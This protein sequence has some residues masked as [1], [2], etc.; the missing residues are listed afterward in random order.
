MKNAKKCFTALCCGIF[1]VA[2]LTG[3]G[4]DKERLQREAAGAAA[5]AEGSAEKTEGFEGSKTIP[6]DDEVAYK[7][8]QAYLESSEESGLEPGTF[9][10]MGKNDTCRNKTSSPTD[11]YCSSCDPDGDNIEG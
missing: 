1:L 9:W 10:C 2:A 4:S 6:E 5:G 7:N 3:C 11:L 8:D